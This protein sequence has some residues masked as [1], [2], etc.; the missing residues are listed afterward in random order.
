MSATAE[1]L[2]DLHELHQRAKALRDRLSSGPK[3]L[4]VRQSTLA[5]RMAQLE[6]ERKALQDAKVQLK[7]HEHDLQGI[8][9]KIDDS[10]TKLNLVKKNDEYKALQNQIAHENAAKS[11]VEEEILVNL[12]DVETRTAAVAKLEAD[13]KRFSGEVVALQQ[14][15]ENE[16]AGH[17]AQLAELEKAIVQAE[18]VIPEEYR[19]QYRRIVGRYGADALAACDEGSCLGCFTSL[20]PQMVNDLINGSGLSFCL[21]CGR[22]LYHEEKVVVTTRRTGG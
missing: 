3:T 22:L 16:T 18:D 19:V 4:A 8:E 14:Q 21:S 6:Q 12:E 9:K 1:N 7:K 20:T 2:R 11:K 10:K 13:A 5:A 17:K 15:I